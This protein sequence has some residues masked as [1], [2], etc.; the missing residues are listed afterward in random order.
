MASALVKKLL[1]KPLLDKEPACF[2]LHSILPLYESRGSYLGAVSLPQ[3]YASEK[4]S[5]KVKTAKI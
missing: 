3:G 1:R 2:T 4:K 5:T